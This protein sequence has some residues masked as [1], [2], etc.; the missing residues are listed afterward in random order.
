MGKKGVNGCRMDGGQLLAVLVEKN[1]NRVGAAV[2]KKNR[3]R[4]R[5]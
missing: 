4:F 5:V 2:W 1:Q 3:F